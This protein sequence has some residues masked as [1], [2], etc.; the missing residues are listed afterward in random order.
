MYVGEDEEAGQRERVVVDDERAAEH[1]PDR[2]VVRERD[3]GHQRGEQADRRDAR[4]PPRLPVGKEQVGDQH[5]DASSR[6]GSSSG[7]SACQ[8]KCGVGTCA[9]AARSTS[10]S[11]PHRGEV[12]GRAV[13][14]RGHRRVER[15]RGLAAHGRVGDVEDDVREDA[16]RRRSAGGSEPTTST[17]T[18]RRR[19][20]ARAANSALGTP[21]A[22]FCSIQSR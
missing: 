22:T 14:D 15:R 7:A 2:A 19:G 10:A 1:R 18:R 12:R 5:D 9:A 13:L 6:R 20:R 21:N 3:D 11:G 17:R 16:E 8:S 4:R